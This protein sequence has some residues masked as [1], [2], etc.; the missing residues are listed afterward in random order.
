MSKIEDL[1]F[2]M[3]EREA[4]SRINKKRI[5]KALFHLLISTLHINAYI[6]LMLTKVVTN[7]IF[8]WLLKNYSIS[9]AKDVMIGGIT[10]LIRV[11]IGWF[12]GINEN[13]SYLA[14]VLI[15]YLF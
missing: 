11:S 6:A 2:V 5:A 7:S 8:R 10:T 12:P 15:D 9:L 4:P 13:A 3:V 1:D 14:T